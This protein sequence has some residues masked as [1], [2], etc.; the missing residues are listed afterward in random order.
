MILSSKEIV[1]EVEAV[2]LGPKRRHVLGHIIAEQAEQVFFPNNWLVSDGGAE[3][4]P[5]LQWTVDE[6]E[7]NN[8]VR[9]WDWVTDVWAAIHTLIISAVKLQFIGLPLPLIYI[10]LNQAVID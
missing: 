9:M 8:T 4:K 5:L 2:I 6:L 3:V 10:I 7:Q 1:P